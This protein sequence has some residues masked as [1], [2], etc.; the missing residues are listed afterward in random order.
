MVPPWAISSEPITWPT[1]SMSSVSQVADGHMPVGGFFGQDDGNTQAGGIYGIMLQ[2]V[3]G[4]DGQAGVQAR[5]QGFAGPGVCPEGGPEAASVLLLHEIPEGLGDAHLPG[6]LLG[7]VLFFVH[8]PAQRAQ[9]LPQ[10]FFQ[11]HPG[12]EIIGPFLRAAGSVLVCG[13]LF[14]AG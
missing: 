3:I 9:Q 10:F 1:C 6:G 5:L 13:Y 14:C 8:R 12:K 2:G 7:A 4:L 11:G